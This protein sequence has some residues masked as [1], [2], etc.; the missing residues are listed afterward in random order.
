MSDQ[1]A[2]DLASVFRALADPLRLRMLA[3]VASDPRGECCVCDLAEL[4]AVSQPTV[5]HHLRVLREAGLLRAERRGT[6]VWYRVTP[7]REPLVAALLNA[8]EG[9]G[10]GPSSI[11]TTPERTSA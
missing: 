3:Q 9:A 4:G 1:S 11:S 5:S 6:W 10:V 7:G 8:V 2:A